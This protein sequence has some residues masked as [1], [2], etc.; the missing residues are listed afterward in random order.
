MFGYLRRHQGFTIAIIVFFSILIFGFIFP[1]FR[2]GLLYYE[3]DVFLFDF[4]GFIPMICYLINELIQFIFPFVEI[5]IIK[6]KFELFNFPGI[7]GDPFIGQFDQWGTRLIFRP[8]SEYLLLGTD[9]YGRDLFAQ[10]AHATQNSLLIGVTTSIIVVTVAVIIGSLAAY[11]GG[12]LDEFL[13]LI[14]NIVIVFPIYPVLLILAASIRPQDRDLG[15][16]AVILAVTTWPWVARAIRAQVMTLR[17]RDF[18]DL[19][20]VSGMSDMRIAAVEVLP[21]MFAYLGLLFAIVTGG[22]IV[23]E[24]GI[25]MLGLGPPS[26]PY[27]TL[28]SM[29]YW[30]IQNESI[31]SE[32]Y[33]AYF[34]PG[35]VLTAFLVILYILHSNLDE[36]F[37]PRLKRH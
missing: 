16:I 6:M 37:N 26:P 23:A 5:P 8:P 1:G 27:I 30:V 31:R 19:A 20:R 18:V 29:L 22:A 13:M 25:S 11:K 33:W 10:L 4:L 2:I 9:D 36:I 34:P 14:T 32:M 24:A 21:N 35:I 17:E 15:L 3:T 28:G 7:V 12:I